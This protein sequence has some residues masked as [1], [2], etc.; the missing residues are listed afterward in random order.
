MFEI[1]Q[2]LQNFDFF[3]FLSCTVRHSNI[4]QNKNNNGMKSIILSQQY[5]IHKQYFVKTSKENYILI[6]N[7]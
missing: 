4:S 5:Q 6:T 3:F 1:F 2:N 7:N